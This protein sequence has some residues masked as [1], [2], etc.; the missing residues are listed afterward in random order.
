[1]RKKKD[2]IRN[3]QFTP[4]E[5]EKIR[6][7]YLFVISLAPEKFL[8]HFLKNSIKLYGKFINHVRTQD[9]LDSIFYMLEQI[10]F[11]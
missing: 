11:V 2:F 5:I 10:R 9:N 3:S 6:L 4:D 8:K 1:M 7:I